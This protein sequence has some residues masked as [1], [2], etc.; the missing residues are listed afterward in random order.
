MNPF[1][2]LLLAILSEIMGTMSL[3]L[4]QGFT[5][6]LPSLFVLVGYGLTFYLLSLS[7]KHIPLSIA[8]AIWAGLGTAGTVLIGTFIFR[9][10][11]DVW[12]VFGIM[13]ILAGVFVLNLVSNAHAA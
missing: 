3:R 12:R 6:P 1:W 8:Y 11:M 2:L 10:T 13:L 7:L 9:E 5:R 4:S